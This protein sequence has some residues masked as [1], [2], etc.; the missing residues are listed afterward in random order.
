MFSNRPWRRLV[1]LT[2]I[3][4]SLTL[5]SAATVAAYPITPEGEPLHLEAGVTPTL[6]A[7]DPATSDVMRSGA[8][9]SP[10]VNAI[11]V[12]EISSNDTDWVATGLTAMASIALLALAAA[13]FTLTG[14]RRGSA[15]GGLTRER[16][17]P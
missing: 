3:C 16:S 6:P 8:A 9:T 12:R 13:A 5:A 11:A 2:T 15:D 10:P 7:A 1:V 4:A 14:R 17:R